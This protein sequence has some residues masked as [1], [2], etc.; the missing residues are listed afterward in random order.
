M[1]LPLTN[2]LAF[3]ARKTW[4]EAQPNERAVARRGLD[5]LKSDWSGQVSHGFRPM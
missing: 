5:V 1:D 4:T 2:G 3:F